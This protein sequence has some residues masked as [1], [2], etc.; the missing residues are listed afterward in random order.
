MKINLK[1]FFELRFKTALN[2][3]ESGFGVVEFK[4][5][6]IILC[7]FFLKQPVLV[8][9][10]GHIGHSG[11]IG[12]IRENAKSILEKT[13]HSVAKHIGDDL[14]AVGKSIAEPLKAAVPSK[15]EVKGFWAYVKENIVE[16]CGYLLIGI[17]IIAGFY[18]IFFRL[19]L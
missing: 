11:H 9:H 17:F 14:K 1:K 4:I 2:R 15:E 19:R 8:G 7:V 5:L 13:D 10:T 16:I 18:Q 3:K 6:L 12:H